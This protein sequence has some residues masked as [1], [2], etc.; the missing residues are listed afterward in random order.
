MLIQTSVHA[1]RPEP[2]TGVRFACYQGEADVGAEKDVGRNTETVIEMARFVKERF[3]AHV[4]AF[5]ELFLSGYGITVDLLHKIA[6]PMD[7][8][9]LQKVAEAA[10][11]NAIT[12]VCPY[13]ERAEE[14][15]ETHF[16]DAIAV[17]GP[18]GKRLVNYRKTHLF[19]TI[20]RALFS[21]GKGPFPTLSINDF[22]CGILNCYEAEFPELPRILAL[23]G[24]KFVIIPTAADHYYQLLDGQR[25]KIP[26]PDISQNLVPA[27]AYMSEIF[28]AYC[29]HVG[30]ESLAS[31]S[32]HF[33]GNS[34]LADPHGKLMLSAP[35]ERVT[36]LV[37]DVVPDDYGPTHPEGNYL[38]DRR[39]GLYQELVAGIP[40]FDDGYE[41]SN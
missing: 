14:D 33:R 24:A 12:I 11:A 25:T 27:N 6:E 30:Y 3:D 34:V 17:F 31:K 38:K 5:P 22:P 2:G 26:Y 41:Y 23:K 40:G 16:Y 39:P 13:P 4:I 32:W 8:P 10:K 20:E 29:N 21:F 1:D 37:G 19:G 28:I 18:D 15:G 35:H 9:H 7:G 36:L